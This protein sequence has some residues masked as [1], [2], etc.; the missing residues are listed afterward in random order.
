MNIHTLIN[1]TSPSSPVL[2]FHFLLSSFIRRLL[3]SLPLP[4]VCTPEGKGAVCI[5]MEEKFPS[6]PFLS[7]LLCLS[8]RDDDCFITLMYNQHDNIFTQQRPKCA[9][10][11]A[12]WRPAVS[13]N[14]A[15]QQLI[16]RSKSCFSHK[17]TSDTFFSFSSESSVVCCDLWVKK[18]V[19]AHTTEKLWQQSLRMENN[20]NN[21]SFLETVR[22]QKAAKQIQV[23][24]FHLPRIQHS[25]GPYTDKL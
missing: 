18:H 5:L 10:T 23:M 25:F 6:F 17:H 7:F 12:M 15:F 11:A 16:K 1:A 24:F 3:L 4:L 20:S 13:K 19:R 2:S 8:L 9:I 21:S 14:T 22:R